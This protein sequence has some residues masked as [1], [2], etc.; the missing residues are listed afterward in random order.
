MKT[1]CWALAMSLGL[2]CFAQTVKPLSVGDK[3]PDLYFHHVLNYKKS[4]ASLS[5]FKGKL[6]ILDL[7]SVSCYN[8][9]QAFP[10]M[11]K[12][13]QQ[14]GD[15]IQV[16]LVNPHDAKY[17]SEERINRVLQ[18]FKTRTG[19]S[20]SLPVPV[21]DSILNQY[22]PHK[23]VPHQVWIDAKGTIVAI[24]GLA[25]ATEENIRQAIAGQPIKFVLKNDHVL[26]KHQPL[27][28]E[29]NWPDQQYDILY[30]SIF[31]RFT[32]RGSSTFVRRDGKGNMIGAHWR[33][34]PL[35]YLVNLA[36]KDLTRGMGRMRI[37]P[38]VSDPAQ[39]SW[40][41]DSSNS[42]C[43]DLI[44]PSA[45]LNADLTP[46]LRE[47]LKRVFNLSARKETRAVKCL[48]F[49]QAD[50]AKIRQLYS[51]DTNEDS[52]LDT[53]SIR[54]FIHGKTMAELLPQLYYFDKPLINE[55][56]I[57]GRLDI[58]FPDHFDILNQQK[59]IAYLET[60]G[61]AIKEEERNMEVVVITDK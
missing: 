42:Y 23:G 45:P 18:K 17:N 52:D 6:V 14:F 26:D 34:I 29:G 41:G 50:P 48:V 58:N 51:K 57:T 4:T 21:H 2:H 56:Q 27:F 13:Q 40:Q 7:W 19:F 33:N 16:L 60:L 47:D 28:I 39:L 3:A 44:I 25:D 1:I 12:L 35:M 46:Y 54:K 36:Y 59:V 20:T 37:M 24:M 15:K 5:D 38:E 30:R 31:T 55:T 49:T 61:F 10:E 8:C 9:I 32:G 43:Y 53:M 11:E 22:F